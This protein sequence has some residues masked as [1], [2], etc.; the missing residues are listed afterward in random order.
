MS[1]LP[2]IEMLSMYE[3]FE[4]GKM[5]NEKIQISGGGALK[6]VRLAVGAAVA[7]GHVLMAP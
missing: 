6:G 7:A 3:A 4:A 5:A 1:P 2:A